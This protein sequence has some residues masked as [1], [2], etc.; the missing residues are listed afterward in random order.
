MRKWCKIVE[1]EKGD[2][3]FYLE[4]EPDED[5]YGLNRIVDFQGV[6]ANVKLSGFSDEPTQEMFD[7]LTSTSIA[8]E[9]ISALIELYAGE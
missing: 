4:Y 8:E 5:C 3:L 7:N 6:R 1:T 9:L 2:V